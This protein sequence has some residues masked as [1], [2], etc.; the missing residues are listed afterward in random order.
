MRKVAPIITAFIFTSRSMGTAGRGIHMYNMYTQHMYMYIHV[1][2]RCCG[3]KI[4]HV[5]TGS[6]SRSNKAAH[7]NSYMYVMYYY[8]T[9]TH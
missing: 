7:A 6:T 3:N 2:A 4:V 9:C 5:Y 8:A 1:Y